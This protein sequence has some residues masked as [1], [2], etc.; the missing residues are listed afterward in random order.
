MFMGTM[1]CG[2]IASAALGHGLTTAASS[3][4]PCVLLVDDDQDG[5][6]VRE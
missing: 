1:L 4:Q 6:D 2:L 5:P 3:L